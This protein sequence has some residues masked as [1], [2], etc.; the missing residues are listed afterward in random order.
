MMKKTYKSAFSRS[1]Y[2]TLLFITL[3]MWAPVLFG[4]ILITDIEDTEVLIYLGII[5]LTIGFFL[6]IFLGTYYTIKN[7]YLYHRSGP[8]MGK[9][10]ISSI[11]KIKYHSG[12]YVPVLYRPATD[13]KGVII[14]YNKYDEIYFS[15]QERDKFVQELLK[16]NP[17]IT[18]MNQEK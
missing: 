17:K 6:W 15:P 1:A 11:A 9:M 16:I 14:T 13:T 12:W 7:G 2:L 18:V 4:D 3:I 8:F 10:K 5:V